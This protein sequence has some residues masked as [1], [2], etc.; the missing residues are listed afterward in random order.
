MKVYYPTVLPGVL[1]VEQGAALEAVP[2]RADGW[3]NRYPYLGDHADLTPVPAHEAE[4][5]FRTTGWV[6]PPPWG[7][8]GNAAKAMASDA[9]RIEHEPAIPASV[10]GD[11]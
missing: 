9:H 4:I 3:E 1:V 10:E 8:Y 5:Q 7:A 2:R 11:S 6:P